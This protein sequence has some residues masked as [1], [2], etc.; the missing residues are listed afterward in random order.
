MKTLLTYTDKAAITLSFLCLLH[1]LSL[2]V[3]LAILPSVTALNLE[4]E[5]YHI[6]MVLIVIP[7]S[8]YALTLGCKQ[9]QHYRLLKIG[10]TGLAF[11]VAAILGEELIGEMGEKILTVIGS[12]LIAYGHY[13]N[14]RLCQHAEDCSCE[15]E[16][17]NE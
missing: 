16:L 10:L 7:T 14:Y 11:L 5:M 1:C 9:H 12:T 6:A 8:L 4:N 2:P 17:I 15:S 13:R 3:L